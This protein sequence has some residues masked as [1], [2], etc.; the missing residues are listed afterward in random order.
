MNKRVIYRNARPSDI[1]AISGLEIRVWGENAA[2]KEN[3]TNRIMTFPLGNVVAIIG[4]KITG[5]VS[6]VIINEQKAE[7]YKSW[8]QYT[9]NGN[10]VNSFDPDGKLLFGA[11]LTVDTDT[12]NEGV[13]SRLLIEIARMSISNRLKAGILGGRLPLYH[14]KPELSVEQYAE[15]KDARGRIFDP[16]LRL[17]KRMGLKVVKFQKDYFNDP[18]SL[19]YGVILR[20]ENPFYGISNILPFLAKPLSMLFRI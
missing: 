19:D 20:W 5:F 2:T 15:L 18:D 10:I 12:R 9:D 1:D 8:Y 6:T 16:E 7:N 3:I 14:T 4:G 13:G 11:S 17:Y